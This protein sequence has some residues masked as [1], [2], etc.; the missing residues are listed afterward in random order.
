M[1]DD[2]YVIR[3]ELS[4]VPREELK[5]FVTG[6][7][8]IVRGERKPPTESVEVPVAI[9]RGWGPFERRF[10]LPQDCRADEVSARYQDGV[11]EVRIDREKRRTPAETTIE[12]A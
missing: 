12:V 5:V 6:G 4:G 9:E 1:T 8:C 2:V 11:L 10:A 7:E 3:V